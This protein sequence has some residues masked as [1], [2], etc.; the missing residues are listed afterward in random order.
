MTARTP[1]PIRY[2][3]R[4]DLR[5]LL[6]LRLA[7]LLCSRMTKAGH[8]AQVVTWEHRGVCPPKECAPSCLEAQTI[9]TQAVE[10]LEA[11]VADVSR[12]LPLLEGLTA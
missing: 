10:H 2:D 6:I 1:R 8:L 7:D 12:Q 4:Y 3:P 11:R 5:D 9:L